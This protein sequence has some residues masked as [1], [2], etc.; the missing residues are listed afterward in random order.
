MI[1]ARYGCPEAEG[2]VL[3]HTLRLSGRTIKKGKALTADDLVDIQ[4]DGIHYVTGA[5]LTQNDM[6]EDNAALKVASALAGANLTIGK[7]MGGRCYLY[8]KRQG[9]AVIDRARID[10]INL[11]DGGISVATLPEY[12]EAVPDQA[13]AS[14]KVIPFAVSHK[15]VAQC[16]AI[17]EGN[18]AAVSL[19]AYRARRVALIMTEAP[20]LKSSVLDSTS[21]V[22]RRRLASMGCQVIAEQRCVHTIEAV[23]EAL[24]LSLTGDCDLVMICGATV[25]AD[26]GDIVPSAIVR[27]GGEIE[28]FGMPVEPGNMLL[29]AQHGSRTIINLPGCGRSPKLN[30][31]DWVL[32]RIVAD[33]PVKRRDIQLMGVGGLIKDIPHVERV[34]RQRLKTQGTER[35][36]VEQQRPDNAASHVNGAQYRCTHRARQTALLKNEL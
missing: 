18:G 22:T 28:L 5:R 6:D 17:A 9:I 36:V 8:A 7:P 12:G 35:Q 27:A 29:L 21:A 26:T 2:V 32:Q 11:T 20:G 33:V 31:L 24:Q 14:I 19:R 16:I 1:F 23:S 3:A 25:T 34:K 30:G 13:V 15:L 10:A 4:R